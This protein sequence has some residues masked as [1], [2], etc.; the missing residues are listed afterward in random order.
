MIPVAVAW[1]ATKN[2]KDSQAGDTQWADCTPESSGLGLGTEQPRRASGEGKEEALPDLLVTD[3]AVG[4][5]F[6]G[7]WTPTNNQQV[8]VI[9]PLQHPLSILSLPRR[10][11]PRSVS[12]RE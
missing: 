8:R 10:G 5:R 3:R 2:G 7:T 4:L 9:C 11:S 12:D 6:S 1:I